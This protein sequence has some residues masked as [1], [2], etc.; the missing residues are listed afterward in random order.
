MTFGD[1]FKKNR[2]LNVGGLAN[3][4]KNCN[5]KASAWQEA[6]DSWEY[7]LRGNTGRSRAWLE[8]P[9]KIERTR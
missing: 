1:K 5:G 3:Q 6:V 9:C 2:N 8:M 7:L 4:V